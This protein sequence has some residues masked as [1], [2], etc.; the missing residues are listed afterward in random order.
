MGLFVSKKKKRE[1]E[2]KKLLEQKEK[3]ES[4]KRYNDFMS[5]LKK[6]MT[7]YRGKL[8]ELIKK[9]LDTGELT[10][11][12]NN[13]LYEYCKQ[14]YKK[15]EGLREIWQKNFFV[16]NP[17]YNEKYDKWREAELERIKAKYYRTFGNLP[18]GIIIGN[19]SHETFWPECHIFP[20]YSLYGVHITDL[21]NSARYIIET[22]YTFE[23]H[24]V[25][26]L[27]E[28]GYRYIKDNEDKEEIWY[29]ENK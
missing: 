6:E 17:D 1:L 25:F 26:N 28:N 15:T 3:E 13:N 18:K 8:H 9:V 2:E 21:S 14:A 23:R 24:V 22:E 29:N 7:E 10:A 27:L 4:D 20:S 5:A 12:D 16:E 19:N 11:E